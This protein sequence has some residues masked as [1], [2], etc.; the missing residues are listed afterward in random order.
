MRVSDPHRA[1][2]SPGR[3][4]LGLIFFVPYVEVLY[5][6]YLVVTELFTIL[7]PSCW[8]AHSAGP[9]PRSIQ[10]DENAHKHNQAKHC[11]FYSLKQASVL[12]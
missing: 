7:N 3:V 10:T 11:L 8:A 2:R 6:T 5:V 1:R 4:R 9:R 12:V